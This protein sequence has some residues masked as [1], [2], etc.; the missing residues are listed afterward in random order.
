M[1]KKAFRKLM[2]S[3]TKTC[4]ISGYVGSLVEHH[5]NGRDIKGAEEDWNKVWVSPNVHDK[6]H[7]GSIIIEGWY[8]TS[9]GRTLIWRCKDQESITGTS[10]TPPIYKNGKCQ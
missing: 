9:D 10:S 1:S 4:P 8:S 6:I 5:I 2:R 7:D 3:G